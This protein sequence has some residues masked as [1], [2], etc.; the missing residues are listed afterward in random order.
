MPIVPKPNH[1]SLGTSEFVAED[2]L[3]QAKITRE[4]NAAAL[5]PQGYTL[6]VTPQGI[7]LCG[8]SAQGL[9]Y[10]EQSLAQLRRRYGE[11]MPCF[12]IRD[13]PALGYRGF[14]IDCCRHFFPVDDLKKMIRAAAAFKLNVFHWHLTEDQ[15]WRIAIEAYPKLAE[16][17]SVR[18]YSKFGRTYEEGTYGGCYSKDDIREIVAFCA[19]HYID[20]IPEFEIPGHASAMLAAYPELSCT[21]EPVNVKTGGGVYPN[22]LCAGNE[23]VYPFVFTVLDEMMA[24]FPYE[25]F[26]IGGDEAPKKNWRECPQC[27]AKILAQGLPGEAA[28]QGYMTNRVAEYLR[29]HGKTAIVWNDALKGGN[30]DKDITVQYWVGKPE[31]C[32]SHVQRGGK[33]IVSEFFHYYLDYSYGQCPLEKTY[34][35]EPQTLFESQDTVLGA[36]APIWTE[37]I[38]DIDKMAYMAWPRLAALA[39]TCWTQAAQKNYNGFEQR[40]SHQLPLFAENGLAIAP[41]KDWNPTRGQKVRMQTKFWSNTVT[42][43]GA[44]MVRNQIR[45]IRK[46]KKLE[47][48]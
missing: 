37:Y 19:E 29:A 30:I 20:V 38:P 5:P 14:M 18:P 6:T 2:A 44:K 26:H 7:Q 36:E 21:K 9:F 24:L 16:V 40:L 22:V 25:Y 23:E 42:W 28:L 13:E 32:K 3:L 4:V 33:V 8:G 31:S 35:Y 41:K 17:G 27:Q 48:S 46:E 11:R 34:A 1:C 15:G 45:E 47:K 43:S 10:A 12:E 39:E